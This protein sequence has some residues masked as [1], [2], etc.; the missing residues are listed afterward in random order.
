MSISKNKKKRLTENLE[1]FVWRRAN[2]P[3]SAAGEVNTDDENLN[4]HEWSCANEMEY[5]TSIVQLPM[6][7][8]PRSI[9]HALDYCFEVLG[10]PAPH[11]VPLVRRPTIRSLAG[12]V[13]TVW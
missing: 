9:G 1:A 2:A 8:T 5:R 7:M 10:K 4:A 3:A 13:P 6:V 11:K 12:P